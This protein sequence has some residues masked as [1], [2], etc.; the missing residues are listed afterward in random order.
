MSKLDR[1]KSKNTSTRATDDNV[2]SFPTRQE[3]GKKF[4]V[5]PLDEAA[6]FA[7]SAGTP[8]AMVWLLLF[9]VAWKEKSKTFPLSS[10]LLA[11]Y[12]VNRWAKWRI[13][14]RL[15]KAGKIKIAR[16]GHKSAIVTI[17]SQPTRSK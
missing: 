7:R 2:V 11:R 15:E 12:D 6:K 4:V 9:Y 17:L 10:E 13:L 8:G 1:F 16:S 3:K 14:T 5:I